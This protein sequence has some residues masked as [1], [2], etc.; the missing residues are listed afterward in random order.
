MEILIP[1]EE[2]V[3]INFLFNNNNY[4]S[5]RGQ[6]YVGIVKKNF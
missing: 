6:F 4:I 3:N 5:N 2:M 1:D